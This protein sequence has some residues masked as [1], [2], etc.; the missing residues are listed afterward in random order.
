MLPRK[1][2]SLGLKKGK[3]DTDLECVPP[4]MPS[5]VKDVE[6]KDKA[7]IFTTHGFLNRIT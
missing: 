6:V 1:L 5:T 3:L 7:P 2:K 4:I